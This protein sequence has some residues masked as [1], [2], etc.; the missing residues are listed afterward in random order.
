LPKVV[1]DAGPLIHLA[2]INKLHLVKKLFNKV[3][4][5]PKVKREVFDEGVKLG[6][7]D[8]Q[9]VGK[10][11]EE[12]WI[13]VKD[14]PKSVASASKRLAEGENISQADAGTLLL[15]KEKR[16]EILVD[17]KALSDLAK[18]Y[19]LKAW[20]TWT[21]L[22][23]SLRRGF[24]EISDIESAI[25]ELGKKRHKLKDKQATEILRAAKFIVSERR[26]RKTELNNP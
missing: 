5:T 21:I 18:M 3:F 25:T 26:G 16:A 23:E 7:A 13:M 11:I 4:V 17:E 2:Q 9:I 14:I 6:H 8:A 20:N 15:A 10:A 1:S 22:L 24:I 19:G 12:G